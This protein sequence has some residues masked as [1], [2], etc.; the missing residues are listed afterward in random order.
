MR[1]CGP[2]SSISSMK[3]LADTYKDGRDYREN[4]RNFFEEYSLLAGIETFKYGQ[5]SIIMDK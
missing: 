1:L 2:G 3:F 4:L 5:V